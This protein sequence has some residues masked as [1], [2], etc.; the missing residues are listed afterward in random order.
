VLQGSID[1]RLLVTTY[2]FEYGPTAAYGSRTAT[3]TLPAGS[4]KVKVSQPVT[5]I[6]LGYHYRLVASNAGGTRD[7]HDRTI[8]TKQKSAFVLPATFQPT[9]VGSPFVLSGT[10]TGPGNASRAIVLQASPYPYRTAFANVGA[11]IATDATGRFSFRVP[12]LT[13]STKFR[14]ATV[15]ARPLYSPVVPEPATVRVVLKVRS[16][17]SAP[18]LVRLYGTVTPAEAGAHVFVQLEKPPKGKGEEEAKAPRSERPIKPEKTKKGGSNKGGKAENSEKLPTYLSEFSTVVKPGTR[19]ISR[20]SV[21]VKIQTAGHY[22][23]FVVVRPGPLA[24]G[25]SQTI[26]LHAA[27]GAKQHKRKHRK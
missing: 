14:V 19:A 10:L 20:F 4:A 6:Q 21:V 23:V 3:G 11:P 12:K 13:I 26:Y 5:G 7:G 27:P 25:H 2:Y 18:G 9:P 16:S 22:R 1:P 24:S 15:S 8:T 17:R